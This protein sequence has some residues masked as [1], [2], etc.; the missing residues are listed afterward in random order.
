MNRKLLLPVVL[1]A[2]ALLS[3]CASDGSLYRSDVYSAQQVNQMQEV[4]TVEIIAIQP[5]RVAVSNTGSRDDARNIGMI[6]GA[7]AG[8]AIGNHGNHSTSARVMGGLAGGALG[9]IAGQSVG[10][11]RQE[12]VNGVQITFRDGNKLY[13]SAQVGQVCEFK[14]GTAIMVSQTPT[15]T[16]I[17]PNN[18]YGCPRK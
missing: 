5:A 2:V 3:A 13:N 9:G 6:L 4:R 10:G 16:R 7:I 18:P 1:S 14:T 17:Q 12:L 11:D 8:A 15:E